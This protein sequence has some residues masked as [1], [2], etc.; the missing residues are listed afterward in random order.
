MYLF[1]FPQTYC[2]EQDGYLLSIET[3]AE[4]AFIKG[5]PSILH[6][7]TVQLK[8]FSQPFKARFTSVCF[9]LVLSAGYGI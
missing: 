3:E 7:L 2:R 5:E 8:S 6:S 9:G 1:Y 4:N